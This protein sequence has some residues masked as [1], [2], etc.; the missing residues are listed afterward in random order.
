MNFK[1]LTDAQWEAMAPHLPNPA[2]TG[3]PRADD[4]R[5]VNGILYVCITGC[6]WAELPKRYGSKSTAHKRLQDWQRNGTWEKLL[7]EAVRQANRQGR[8]QLEAISVDS[9]T[10]PAKKGATR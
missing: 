7:R 2:R 3:R 5:T 4:R 10:V 1:E 9:S 8:L 6:R